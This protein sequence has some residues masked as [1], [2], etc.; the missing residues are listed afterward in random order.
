MPEMNEVMFG[1]ALGSFDSRATWVAAER[2]GVWHR[3]QIQPVA[4]KAG[5]T[6]KVT[7]QV[8]IEQSI[9][10]VQCVLQEP[11]ARVLPLTRAETKWDMFNWCY[12]QIWEG[13]L[14]AYPDGTVVR[15]TVEALPSCGSTSIPADKGTIFSYFVGA[16]PPPDWATEARIYQV[17]VDRFHPG[18]GRDW[19][20]TDD[21]DK[22][23]GGTLQGVIEK[24]DYLADLGINCLW[25]SPLFPDKT[26]HGYHPLDYFAV[27]PRLGTLDDARALIREAHARE[28]HVLL[29]FVANHFGRNHPIFQKAQRERDSDE[30]RWFTWRD[31]PDAYE[32]YFDIPE[33]PK[34][35]T[36]YPGA[37]DYLL[38]SVEFWLD[39]VGFDGMRL[40]HAS[41]PTHDFWTATRAL[42]EEIKPDAWIFGE[43][44]LS[45]SK[46]RT[47]TGRLHG[48][49]DFPLAQA[50]R[51]T[52]AFGTMSLQA[53]DAFVTHHERYFPETFRLPG[54]LD[55]HDMDRFLYV[56]GGNMHNLKLAAL[57]LLTL[58]G[59][60][61]LYNGT[62]LGLSQEKAIN[63]QDSQGMGESRLPMPWE[64]PP[65]LELRDFFRELLHFR[66]AHPVLWQGERRTLH[67]DDAAQTY[68]YAIQ[69]TQETVIVA[70]N[71]GNTSHTLTLDNPATGSKLHLDLPPWSG[72][73]WVD[74]QIQVW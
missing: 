30:Y 69:D 55:N 11:E 17:F 67:V 42:I 23:F 33:L 32:A 22:P 7:V 48:A 63:A 6:P 46:L 51:D 14:P 71:R 52:F 60:P 28:M 41:G 5:D 27:N 29:D 34:I 57:C 39:D 72:L 65:H 18:A 61:I 45:P 68:V 4:P 26:Y 53:F 74:D 43:M 19:T 20:Q 70:L 2:K 62:E 66:K 36:D 15:Y 58:S 59:P 38:R 47:Y 21:L 40:D 16:S 44:T 8:E 54:F 37:R 12:T 64:D 73:T 3:H 9:S 56:A 35:N 31:W 50:L 49:L 10:Q 24:L 1:Y 25:I 13:T